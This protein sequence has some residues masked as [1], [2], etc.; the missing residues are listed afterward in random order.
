MQNNFHLIRF[1]AATLVLYGHC[2]PLSGRG[3]DYLTEISQGIF[4]TAHMGVCIFF[5]VSGYL[6]SK[7]LH[8]T[9]FYKV[10]KEADGSTSFKQ[11]LSVVINFIWKRIVRI[12][13]ALVVVLLLTVLVLGPLCT[14]LPLS[15]YWQSSETYRYLK[16]VK[17]YPF[18]DD[19]LPGVFENLPEKGINGSLWTL[20]YEVTMYFCLAVLQLIN[21]FSKRNILLI[22]FGV[23]SPIIVF[24]IFN[25]NQQS[26]I[27]VIHL[28]FIQTLE[29][30]MYFMAG[31][32]FFL[33]DD[34]IPYHIGLFLLMIFLWF[35]LGLLHLTN[36]DTIKGISFFALPYMV[37]YLAKQKGKLNDFSKL[38]DFSYGI[39][40][41]AFPVQQAVIYFYGTNI[42]IL[43]MF[44][45]SAAIVLP[46]SILSW[47]LVEERAM[48][49]KSIKIA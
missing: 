25:Y 46:L 23:I 11:N 35:G 15:E 27:P 42:S 22:F 37:I 39:Y 19:L 40:L 32:L 49:F 31:T 6:V 21:L 26:L 28:N 41:Y 7:S 48:R 36:P 17:L 43:K 44:L 1:V 10:K 13:P 4:P 3:Y 33:F 5:V 8:N 2:Y 24:F 38:G 29:F 14:T 34:K 9:A 16:F 18:V 12:F 47:F 45:I 30:S 20:P